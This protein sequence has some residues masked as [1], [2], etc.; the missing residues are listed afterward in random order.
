MRRGLI[1]W[2]REEVPESALEARVARLQAA[3]RGAG[4]DALIVYTS[5]ARPAAVAW[6]THFVPYWN[7]GLLL[8]FPSGDPV[9]LAAF[10]RRVLDWIRQV[11]RVGEVRPA[12]DLGLAAAECLAQR[13]Q[14][15]AAVGV[16]ELDR[17]PWPVA[18]ALIAHRPGGTL[19]DA[20]AVYAG[21]RQPADDAE[22]GLARRASQIAVEAFAAIPTGTRRASQLLAAVERAARLA[23]AEDLQLRLATDLSSDAILRRIEDDAPLASRHALQVRLTYKAV[24]VRI[25]RSLCAGSAPRSWQAAAAWLA[26]AGTGVVEGCFAAPPQAAPG[27]LSLWLLESGL[28]S[29]PLSVVPENSPSPALREGS[30]ASLS[31][32]L[33]L[34]DGPWLGGGAL[35]VGGRGAGTWLVPAGD[36]AGPP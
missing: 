14:A 13:L 27:R 33:D 5:F 10:S 8:V 2:S 31:V 18:A 32:K 30:L 16:V 23:G 7:D 19:R 22:T 20:T 3:M 24:C 21:A 12:P 28:G 29:E 17:L 11:S 9:L 25:T 34:D 36:R 4:L 26:K 6:L 15:S 1:G 35:R